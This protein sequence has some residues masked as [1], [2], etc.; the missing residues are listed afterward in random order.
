MRFD[1]FTND[2]FAWIDGQ[3]L[4]QDGLRSEGLK[5]MTCLLGG[6]DMPAK[7]RFIIVHRLQPVIVEQGFHQ[8]PFQQTEPDGDEIAVRAQI[9]IDAAIVMLAV[10]TGVIP[11]FVTSYTSRRSVIL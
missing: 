6:L 7:Q 3:D 1:W 10:H 8:H 5:N 11:V 9:E 2:S 4:R